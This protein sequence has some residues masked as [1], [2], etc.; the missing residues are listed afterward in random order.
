MVYISLTFEW[1]RRPSMTESDGR[2]C[3]QALS[4]RSCCEAPHPCE[5]FLS[6]LSLVDPP[7]SSSNSSTELPA[8]GAVALANIFQQS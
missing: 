1:F 4:N 8:V 5:T 7:D 6:K 2:N 3:T